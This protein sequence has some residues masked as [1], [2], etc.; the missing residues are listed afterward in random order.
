MELTKYS[1]QE[2][3]LK[4]SIY[5]KFKKEHADIFNRL[6]KIINVNLDDPT[7]FAVNKIFLE[8]Q[9]EKI[10]EL[11][12]DI[13]QYYGSA[14]YRTIKANK[15]NRYMSIFRQILKDNGLSITSKVVSKTIDGKKETNTFYILKCGNN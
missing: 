12:D 3:K 10:E 6:L 9:K 1:E 5:D 7:T 14:F 11:Y 4:P 15:E 13:V 2:I 8:L